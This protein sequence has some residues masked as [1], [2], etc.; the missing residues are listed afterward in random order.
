[1][2][3]SSL[4]GRGT[5]DITGIVRRLWSSARRSLEIAE[6]SQALQAMPDYLLKDIGVDR[7]DIHAIAADLCD[8]CSER[9]P[10]C[11]QQSGVRQ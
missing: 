4:R 3:A 11:A 6:R 2:T 10:V 5:N 9:K 8:R 7:A 1:M